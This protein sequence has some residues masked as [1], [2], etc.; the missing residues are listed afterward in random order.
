[1]KI[2]PELF[3]LFDMLMQQKEGDPETEKFMAKM[4]QMAE[5]E[6]LEG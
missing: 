5:G 6:S 3:K 1:L 2:D 4:M